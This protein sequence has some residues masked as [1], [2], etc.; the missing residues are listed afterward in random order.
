[1]LVPKLVTTLALLS[2]LRYAGMPVL[3]ID[4]RSEDGSWEHFIKL[5]EAYDFDLLSAP[6]KKHGETPQLAL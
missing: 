4:C 1:M 6:L 3:I 2:A 5:M